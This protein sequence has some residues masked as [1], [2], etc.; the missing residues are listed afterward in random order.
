ML[1]LAE[2]TKIV[3]YH[4]AMIPFRALD[5]L[6]QST[7]FFDPDVVLV[8][9]GE[10]GEYFRTV[11]APLLHDGR[12]KSKVFAL[13][14]VPP[15][16]VSPFVASADLGVV[17]YQNVNL[18]NYYCAPMKLYEYL[19]LQIPIAGCDFPP[20][21]ELLREYPVG[22]TFD[23]ADSVSIAA[24]INFYFRKT[25]AEYAKTMDALKR[26]RDRFSWEEEGSKWTDLVSSVLASSNSRDIVAATREIS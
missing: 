7:Q 8:L 12:F 22:V 26:A 24:A 15:E 4:G 19:M 23:P 11:L 16:A 18:N 20:I 13:P 6:I 5:K 3:I 9:M 21:S 2:S 10:Q 1:G 14:F 17:I 25:D